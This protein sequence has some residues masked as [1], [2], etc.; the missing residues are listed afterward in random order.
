MMEK[1]NSAACERNR[2]PILAVLRDHF[3]DRRHV[4]EIGSGTGQ[5]AVYFAAALPQLIWQT[6]DRPEN[7]EGIR[8]WL[9]EAGLPN[10]LPPLV[11]DVN[12]TDWT[13]AKYS[14]PPL[15]ERMPPGFTPN[16]FDSI[17]TANTL[18]IMSWP[19]VQTMFTRLPQVLAADAKL[20]IYGPFNYNG[21]FTSESN[22]RFQR[23]LKSWGEH[24]GIRDFEAADALARSIGLH[25][26]E[27]RAMPAN[28]RCLV[29][30]R[31]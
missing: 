23:T 3:A 15:K 11:L 27:D 20:V 12:H 6:S 30:A 18:H 1:P 13:K 14:R 4:L 8:A 29:W 17:F 19:E 24:M 7:H 31:P 28:N 10:A 16:A 2:D 22:A 9:E 25:L 26:V 21:Q 5:H